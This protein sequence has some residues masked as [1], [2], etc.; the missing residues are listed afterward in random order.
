M[1]E[2]EKL[3]QLRDLM[4]GTVH[5][6]SQ[7]QMDF[8]NWAGVIVSLMEE[9][10]D[11]AI[12][13][14]QVAD[15]SSCWPGS[16]MP[17]NTVYK[18]NT[19]NFSLFCNINFLYT[20]LRNDCT[21]VNLLYNEGVIGDARLRRERLAPDCEPRGADLEN[22]AQNFKCQPHF[23]C[24]YAPRRLRRKASR[25]RLFGGDVCPPRSPS[26]GGAGDTMPVC[27]TASC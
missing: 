5:D 20:V 23:L 11:V 21:P 22:S 1:N 26:G 24:C 2:S 14:K 15:L 19:G 4:N 27:R 3:V 8:G 10:D 9:M 7:K 18:P 12:G 6:L 25:Y 17:S 16:M 13:Q